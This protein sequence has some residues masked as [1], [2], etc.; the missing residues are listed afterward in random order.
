MG[1]NFHFNLMEKE[2]RDLFVE[3][4]HSNILIGLKKK[5]N[6]TLDRRDKI[7]SSVKD[8]DELYGPIMIG[9]RS[10]NDIRTLKNKI[11]LIIF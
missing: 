7:K 5:F 2:K 11:K 8:Y 6:A 4:N 3:R 1:H 9:D 10:F